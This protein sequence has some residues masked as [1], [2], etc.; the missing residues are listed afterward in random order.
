[1]ARR[2]QAEAHASEQAERWAEAAA[3]YEKLAALA[4]DDEAREQWQAALDRSRREKTLAQLFDDGQAALEKRQWQRAQR[5][6]SEVVYGRPDYSVDGRLAA[7]LLL[8]AVLR[9]PV[10]RYARSAVAALSI[11]LLTVVSVGSIYFWQNRP[12]SPPVSLPDE[13]LHVSTTRLDTNRDTELEW[14]VLYRFDSPAGAASSGGPIAGVVY[15]AANQS[16]ASPA[17]YALRPR[18]GDYLCECTCTAAMEERLSE[19]PGPE[20]VVRDHCHSE[21]T[22]LSIFYWD[23]AEET[24]QPKGHFNGSR[25]TV[26]LDRVTVSQ[27]L[28]HR[29][30][31]ALHQIYEARNGQTYYQPGGLG[32]LTPPKYAWAFYYAEPSDVTASPYPEKVVLAFYNHYAEAGGATYF[33]AA[34]WRDVERCLTGRCG[35][36][37]SPDEIHHVR[38]TDLQ[39]VDE[40][41]DRAILNSSVVCERLNGTSEAETAVRW[42]LVR[43]AGHWLLNGAE[44]SPTGWRRVDG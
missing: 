38:V 34:G 44:M 35:C 5:A 6:L 39:V 2:W 20:L 43:D 26:E 14:M 17:S 30:Q 36:T 15:Q 42:E 19:L 18:D 13:W 40:G 27:R 22:R 7:R 4:P 10:R 21:L 12:L 25:I 9:K 29:A 16:G 8:Q 41:L 1:L 31:L 37:S 33:T 28:P 3:V 11:L 23:A 32:I 24:Y